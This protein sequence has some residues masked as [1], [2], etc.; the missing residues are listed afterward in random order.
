MKS[1][2]LPEGG[3]GPFVATARVPTDPLSDAT[4]RL[5]APLAPFAPPT[6]PPRGRPPLPVPRKTV[7]WG[8]GSSGT[9]SARR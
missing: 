6:G 9:R 7:W 1:A 3:C 8:G 5:A 2:P 4:T